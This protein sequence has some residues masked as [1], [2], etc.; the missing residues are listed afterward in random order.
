MFCVTQQFAYG[1]NNR[2][3]L[4]STY[5]TQRGELLI[6]FCNGN[7]AQ[8]DCCREQYSSKKHHIFLLIT[9]LLLIIYV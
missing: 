6:T 3:F 5:S 4:S 1:I 7:S 8:K 9:N 2:T